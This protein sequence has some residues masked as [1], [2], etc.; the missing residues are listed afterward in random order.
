MT[1]TIHNRAFE[2]LK[3]AAC[4]HAYMPTGLAELSYKQPKEALDLLRDW[5]EGRKPLE[6]LY[7]EVITLLAKKE[8][9]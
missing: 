7:D 6:T 8:T 9:P 4:K 3:E 1:N 2:I 5:G